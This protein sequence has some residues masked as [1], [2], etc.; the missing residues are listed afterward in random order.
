MCQ[1]PL[2]SKV[3]KLASGLCIMSHR[4]IIR[5]AKP[6]IMVEMGFALEDLSGRENDGD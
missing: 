5:S 2:F 1:L 6:A 4:G 3:D